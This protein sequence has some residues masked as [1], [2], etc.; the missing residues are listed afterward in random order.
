MAHLHLPKKQIVQDTMTPLAP[1]QTRI[2][3]HCQNY[4]YKFIR[5]CKSYIFK[6]WAWPG[7]EPG[8]SRT[9]SENHTPRPPSRC[10]DKKQIIRDKMAN[11]CLVRVMSSP[12]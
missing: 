8:T 10:E 6:R 9:L 4:T 3:H 2:N 5:L 1:I 7:I 12:K 11:H